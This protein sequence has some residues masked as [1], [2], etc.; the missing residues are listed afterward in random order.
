M[1]TPTTTISSISVI[2]PPCLRFSKKLPPRSRFK[3][4]LRCV[5]ALR[6]NMF[7]LDD[8]FRRDG[9]RRNRSCGSGHTTPIVQDNRRVLNSQGQSL[10]CVGI[11]T[12]HKSHLLLA[13]DAVSTL[14]QHLV[15]SM[16]FTVNWQDTL[17]EQSVKGWKAV[18]PAFRL[19]FS[20]CKVPNTCN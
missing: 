8:I 17:Q 18:I 6:L 10:R 7:S 20:N 1:A 15:N 9:N 5:A 3:Q 14:N 12:G 19:E 13:Y 11:L 2:K 16:E 4:S